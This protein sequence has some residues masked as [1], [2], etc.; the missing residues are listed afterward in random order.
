M[1]KDQ[2]EDHGKQIPPKLQKFVYSKEYYVLL[3]KILDYCRVSN[4]IHA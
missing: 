2:K 1:Q 3:E 4:P